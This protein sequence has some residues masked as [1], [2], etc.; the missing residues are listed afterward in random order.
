MA[1]RP[2]KACWLVAGALLGGVSSTSTHAGPPEDARRAYDAGRFTNAMG[3]W[4]QLGREGNAEA[5]LGLGLLYDQGNATPENPEAAFALYKMAAEAGLPVAEFNV[6]ALYES[7]R[8]VAQNPESAA[9]WFAKAGAHGHHRAQFDVGLLYEQGDGVA[10]NPDAAA[11]WFRAAAGGGVTAAGD[12]LKALTATTRSRG[13][14]AAGTALSSVT[15]ASPN[16]DANLTLTHESPIVELVW[17][18]PAQPQPVHY[19]VQLHE[20]D[21]PAQ[22]I[23]YTGSVAETATV[24]RLPVDDA[25]Y[26]WRIDVVAPD[27]SRGTG[28]WSWFS[29]G[30]GARCEQSMTSSS[31][32][33]RASR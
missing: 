31:S 21:G 14:P 5:E 33:P 6:G 13:K 10:Q 25:F 23:S 27:G 9:L 29:V 15:L 26:I 12:R 8:G 22:R 3:I 4:A 19:E 30:S 18:A 1:L 20:M 2:G 24:V 16:R 11:V 7:G 28:D 17:I 32:T